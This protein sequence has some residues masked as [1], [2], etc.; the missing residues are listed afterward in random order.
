MV[1]SVV[2]LHILLGPSWCMSVA[3][4][5]IRLIPNVGFEISSLPSF[6]LKSSNLM[7]LN[8]LN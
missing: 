5:G 3:L 1:N 8:K 7:E 4:F 2:W 6:A